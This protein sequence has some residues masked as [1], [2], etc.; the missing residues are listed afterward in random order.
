M[1]PNIEAVAEE[2]IMNVMQLIRM[3]DIIISMMLLL[4][5]VNMSDIQLHLSST[6]M[7]LMLLE[8][9]LKLQQLHMLL[10]VRMLGAMEVMVDVCETP[11]LR[12]P[13]NPLHKTYPR[14][15][16]SSALDCQMWVVSGM[17]CPWRMRKV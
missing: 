4:L 15:I 8:A 3:M 14:G 2:D 10:L 13:L 5:M 11:S 7:V 1:N 17:G 6:S 9:L 16:Q 12:A